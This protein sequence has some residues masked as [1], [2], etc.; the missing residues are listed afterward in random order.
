MLPLPIGKAASKEIR[1]E[2]VEAFTR[3]QPA[4]CLGLGNVLHPVGPKERIDGGPR[5]LET[6]DR[7]LSLAGG[8][9]E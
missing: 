5:R 1:V 8:E 2:Q 9:R 6:R 4:A 3:L 7:L